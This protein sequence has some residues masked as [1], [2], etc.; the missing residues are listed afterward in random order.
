MKNDEL[1]VKFISIYLIFHV[2]SG[3]VLLNLIFQTSWKLST[4]NKF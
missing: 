2:L 4:D 1:M 3:S